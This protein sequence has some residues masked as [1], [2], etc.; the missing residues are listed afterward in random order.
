MAKPFSQANAYRLASFVTAANVLIATGFSIA[1]ITYPEAILPF[2]SFPTK[3]S[4][5]FAM[6][7]A[8]RTIPLTLVIL[9]VIFRRSIS[10]LIIMGVL[11]G[12]VQL[13]DSAVGLYQQ[14]PG[15]TIG[16]FVIGCLQLYVVMLL[17]KSTQSRPTL[18]VLVQKEG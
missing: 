10:T 5:I 7:A 15:K 17:S 18:D 2:N 6:Y 3:A 9:F 11:V 8:A 13:L 12:A 1:G 16:P 4:F 14:D